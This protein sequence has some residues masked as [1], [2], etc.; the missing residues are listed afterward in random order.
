MNEISAVSLSTSS[1]HTVASSLSSNKYN[2]LLYGHH[3]STVEITYSIINETESFFSDDYLS[4]DL[5]EL[6]KGSLNFNPLQ[7][8]AISTA[9]LKWSN[10]TT[11]NFS[12]IKETDN[13]FGTIRF[14]LSDNVNT[15]VGNSS[16]FAFFPSNLE[17]GG[18]IWLN[19]KTKDIFGGILTESFSE[20]S[21]EEASFSYSIL[22]HEIGHA[23]GLKHPF[24][25]SARNFDTLA[26]DENVISNTIMSYTVSLSSDV[27]GLTAYPTTPM[28]EDIKAIQHLYGTNNTFN[29][30]NTSY[31]FDDSTTYFETIWDSGG[32]D[33]IVYSGKQPIELS[34]D[35]ASGSFIGKRVKG[36]SD[37]GTHLTEIKNIYIADFVTIENASGGSGNDL[38]EGNFASNFLVGGKGNDNL[39]GHG[40]NDVFEGGEGNDF[41]Y[42]GEGVDIVLRSLSDFEVNF[43]GE[44][45]F[46]L[47]S[48]GYEGIDSLFNVERIYIGNLDSPSRIIGLDINQG[49]SSGSV[50]RLYNAAFN[51][52]PDGFEVGYHVNDIE[53]NEF[54]LLDIARN[55]LLSPEF[56]KTYGVNQ[57]DEDYVK[58]LI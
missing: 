13:S 27:V 19:A 36:Y 24:E 57:S 35:S 9:L 51:R 29:F 34:L 40:A 45:N 55:F 20:S 2:A 43:L 3:W 22:V 25:T 7:A 31:F 26:D 28:I 56:S 23:L 1:Q 6:I 11:I 39:Y 14:G 42:G 54:Q 50:F 47:R 8:L 15:L 49:E 53:N 17:T 38:I 58:N 18:D 32:T 10:V 16:A 12:E 41:I 33:E 30:G 21:F 46:Q 4:D 48:S 52:A 5:N 44:Q 37:N